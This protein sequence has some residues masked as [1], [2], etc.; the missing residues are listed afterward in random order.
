[1]ATQ[2]GIIKLYAEEIVIKVVSKATL[3]M[4]EIDQLKLRSI[5]EEVLY[6]YEIQPACHSLVLRNDMNNAILLYLAAKRLDGRSDKTLKGYYRDLMQFASCVMK[7]VTDVTAMDIRI[8]LA[9]YMQEHKLRNST[10]EQKKSVFHSFFGWLEDQGYIS[11]SP[12]KLIKPTKVEKRIRQA[13]TV[14]ALEELKDACETLRQR[15]LV[16]YIVA[17]GARVS[18]VH[19]TDIADLNWSEGTLRVIGKGNKQREVCF[20]G[21]AKYYIKK[22][23]NSRNDSSP[24]LF[25]TTKGKIH[26]LGVRSIEKEMTK[27]GINA[28]FDKAIF[29]HLLRHTMATLNLQSGMPITVI[30]KLLGHSDIATTQIYAQLN[31]ETVKSEYRKHVI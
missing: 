14:E 11:K 28:G 9:K 22:Y 30:Q 29:P 15:A 31:N 18:E 25:V 16:E 17:T 21:K 8:Y 3:E 5:M 24:A 26:R 13:L 2:R 23:L 4:P 1:M 27:I 10:I 12:M 7:N 19:F 20:S 6:D